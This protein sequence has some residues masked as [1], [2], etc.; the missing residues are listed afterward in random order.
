MNK[1]SV[2][3]PWILE[4]SE[5]IREN[6]IEAKRVAQHWL[7]AEKSRKYMPR[8]S[9]NDQKRYGVEVRKYREAVEASCNKL[10]ASAKNLQRRIDRVKTLKEF[11]SVEYLVWCPCVRY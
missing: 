3:Y 10:D 2:F 8:W 1:N 5:A 11:V 4:V 7:S 6:C 9:E